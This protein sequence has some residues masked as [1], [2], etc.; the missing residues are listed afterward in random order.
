MLP[1]WNGAPRPQLL[2]EWWERQVAD[3]GRYKCKLGSPEHVKLISQP[4][5]LRLMSTCLFPI[6]NLQPQKT[7]EPS[8]TFPKEGWLTA[9]QGRWHQLSK[10]GRQIYAPPRYRTETGKQGTDLWLMHS[11]DRRKDN[12]EPDRFKFCPNT[13]WAFVW[14]PPIQV[15]IG[16]VPVRDKPPHSASTDG[17]LFGPW[18]LCGQNGIVLGEILFALMNNGKPSSC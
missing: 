16:E 12:P 18:F 3:D 6:W 9:S 14:L 4:P 5:W 7:P 17:W 1:S 10:G 13:I 2:T 11:L 8:F 15:I